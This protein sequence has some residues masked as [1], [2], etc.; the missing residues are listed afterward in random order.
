MPLLHPPQGPSR[1]ATTLALLICCAL[2]TGCTA[3]T[4]PDQG[5]SA[6]QPEPSLVSVGN[7]EAWQANGHRPVPGIAP[8][9]Y[10]SDPMRSVERGDADRQGVVRYERDGARVP[11]PVLEAQFG[12]SM[13]NNFRLSKDERYLQ[14][15]RENARAIIRQA[16]RRNN[17]LWHTYRFD[18]ALHS[19]VTNTIHA[20]W[21]S[22]MAQGQ[23]LSLLVRLHRV[24]GGTEWMRAARQTFRS[25]LEVHREGSLPDGP[26]VVFAS[27]DN[28]LWL[29]EYAGDVEPMRVLNGH[30]FAMYGLYDYWSE[31]DDE[32]A[33]MLFDGA[34]STVLEF[35]PRLR[36]K[37]RP[38]WYGM[39]VQDNP[40]AMSET[41]HRIHIGQL[42][43]LAQMTDNPRFAEL[44]RTLRDDF[45]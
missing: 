14:M 24:D 18:F 43:M 38:S 28:W 27:S 41:Y 32:R 45:Y 8:L 42:D 11:H 15:A 2:L 12:L 1:R 16:D 37:G 36:N 9:P 29:E 19:D 22:A 25:F 3:S 35:V 39:R 33:A 40:V 30:I 17:V 7:E 21:W 44:S 20:P 34:A 13:L 10:D 6:E 31:T 4:T 5:E 23:V 26:W